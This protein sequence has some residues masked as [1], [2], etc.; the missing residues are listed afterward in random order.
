MYSYIEH[1]T[2]TY[3]FVLRNFSIQVL[4]IFGVDTRNVYFL[5]YFCRVI[6]K[7]VSE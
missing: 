1:N 3:L 4:N 5:V 2:N 7:N 6:V